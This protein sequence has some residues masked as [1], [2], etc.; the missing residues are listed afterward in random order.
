MLPHERSLVER[1]KNLPF[2][3]VGIA[4]EHTL[5]RDEWRAKCK[6]ADVTW[7]NAWQGGAGDGAWAISERWGVRAYPTLYLVDDRGVISHTWVGSPGDQ[8]LDA[9]V[10]ALIAEAKAR[11]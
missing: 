9:A 10:D 7:R 4:G 6:Q 1:T 5:T 8:A 11:K 2:A 3:L